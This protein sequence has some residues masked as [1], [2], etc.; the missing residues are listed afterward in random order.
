[1]HNTISISYNYLKKVGEIMDKGIAKN[2]IKACGY[3]IIDE[4][5]HFIR[6]RDVFKGS[7]TNLYNQY[8]VYLSRNSNDLI[9]INTETERAF[10]INEETVLKEIFKKE[11]ALCIALRI[12]E[13]YKNCYENAKFEKYLNTIYKNIDDL[14]F[15]LENL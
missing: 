14:P 11:S 15:F 4:N 9:F 3:K 7:N 1:M 6:V 2:Y 13:Q 5:N 12:P 8:D 10:I